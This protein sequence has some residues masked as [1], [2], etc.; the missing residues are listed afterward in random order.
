MSSSKDIIPWEPYKAAVNSNKK[1]KM[2][3]LQQGDLV[4]Y[5]IETDLIK[6]NDQRP[7]HE[8]NDFDFNLIE[9]P[10]LPN[11]LE[12]NFY[13]NNIKRSM[14]T[15]LAKNFTQDGKEGPNFIDARFY[16]DFNL[17]KLANQLKKK[18]M[19]NI[20]NKPVNIVGPMLEKKVSDNFKAESTRIW[21]NQSE[22][23]QA[24][25]N[26][27]EE[28]IKGI[29]EQL[30]IQTEVNAE[31]KKLLVAAIGGEDMEYK[32][33]RLVK[34]KQ[35]YEIE[36]KCK[37][38]TINRLEEEIEQVSIQ[39]DLWRSKFLAS[40]LLSEENSTWLVKIISFMFFILFYLYQKRDFKKR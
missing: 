9:N 12:K 37:T 30:Q 40:K 29:N 2:K 15:N 22:N 23:Y 11:A 25:I 16:T 28:Q 3:N 31:L 18:S 14:S 6:F 39:C 17:M 4:K 13:K 19:T 8:F 7:G 36:I 26:Y 5:K 21:K 10:S 1:F 32:I 38:N 33:E 20:E 27:L 35:R 24:R 34:D